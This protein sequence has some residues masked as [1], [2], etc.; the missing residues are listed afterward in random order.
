MR[1]TFVA[2]LLHWCTLANGQSCPDFPREFTVDNCTAC[3]VYDKTRSD[4]MMATCRRRTSNKSYTCKCRTFPRDTVSPTLRYFALNVGHETRCVPYQEISPFSIVIFG[5]VRVATGLYAAIHAFYIALR[6]GL[7]SCKKCT[8]IA[9][10]A[11]SIGL[12]ILVRTSSTLWKLCSRY[13]GF[14]IRRGLGYE[15]LSMFELPLWQ[16]SFAI[17]CA[18]IAVTVYPREDQAC[19]RY[20]VYSFFPVLSSVF[21]LLLILSLVITNVF[22]VL[23]LKWWTSWWWALL[24]HALNIM[25]TIIVFFLIVFVAIVHRKMHKVS[26]F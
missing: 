22:L 15:V 10:S 11:L 20:F 21:V 25:G 24:E 18:N 19:R 9:A 17:F 6:S 5:I 2:I 16:L 26:V 8:K 13:I 12:A 3:P 4:I 7:W 23:G 14:S 1:L